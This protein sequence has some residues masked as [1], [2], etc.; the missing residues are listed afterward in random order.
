MLRRGGKQLLQQVQQLR[1]FA[2][3]AAL[4]EESPFLRF[5]QPFAPQLN[6]SAALAQ[7]P[8]TKV[9]DGG[10]QGRSCTRRGGPAPAARRCSARRRLQPACL[11]ACCLTCHS[12]AA[13][14]VPAGDP[15]AQ[16][17]ACGQRDGAPFQ[18]R[19]RGRVDRRGQP[20]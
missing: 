5:G 2:A 17:P 16:R 6:M 19:H 13:R 15:P 10:L 9:R 14:L 20:V 12:R 4:A 1:G 18:H 11:P 3:E 7:L 8:E